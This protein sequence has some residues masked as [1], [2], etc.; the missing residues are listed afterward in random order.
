MGYSYNTNTKFEY[1]DAIVANDNLNAVLDFFKKFPEYKQNG[2]WI[3]GESYAGKYIPDL[4]V[5]IDQYN[6]FN[7]N[8]T[9]KI[10]LKGILVGNG[11]MSWDTLSQSEV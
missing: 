7:D 3:A 5:L 6:R 11:V 2:F 1:N 10:N 9:F 4:A 8:A